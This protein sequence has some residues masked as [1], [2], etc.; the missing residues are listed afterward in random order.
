MW[1][2]SRKIENIIG[3]FK[4]ASAIKVINKCPA[5]I[6]AA[7][8]IDNVKGRIILLIVSIITIKGIKIVGVPL[9]IKWIN[10]FFVLIKDIWI[11]K[12]TH[13]GSAKDNVN[14]IC[15][16]GVKIPGNKPGILFIII[17]K[18]K[19]TEKINI[20]GYFLIKGLNS[21][22][23]LC[24][25]KINISIIWLGINQIVK[26][27]IRIQDIINNQFIDVLIDVVGSKIEKR[28]VIMIIFYLK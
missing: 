10:L 24:V 9:G 6:L 8:R 5:I 4:A 23:S 21:F 11:I 28:L 7:N 3:V 14:L 20:C 17:N 1:P 13:N 25:T 2:V 22:K 18:N 27:K 15:L 26:G 16:V 19:D 12:P